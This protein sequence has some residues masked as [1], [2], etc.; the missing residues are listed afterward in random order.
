LQ[1]P[2]GCVGLHFFNPVSRLQLVEVV[3]HD[4]TD[5]QLLKQALAFVG[6]IDRLPLPV[7]SSPGFSSTAR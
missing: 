4:G 3:S 1:G 6:A 2:S 5:A 7:K